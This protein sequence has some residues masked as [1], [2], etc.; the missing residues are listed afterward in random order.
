[1]YQP[2]PNEDLRL[3]A[4]RYGVAGWQVADELGISS[5]TYFLWLRK[6]LDADTWQKIKT[7]IEKVGGNQ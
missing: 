4:R 1:M 3:L 5:S 7:A 6:E 2:K